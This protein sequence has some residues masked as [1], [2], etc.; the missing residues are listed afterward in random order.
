MTLPT[1]QPDTPEP[2]QET[3][4][5]PVANAWARLRRLA[6]RPEV[7]IAL[8]AFLW[9]VGGKLVAVRQLRSSSLLSAGIAV[10]C[11]DVVFF[12]GGLLLLALMY[13][14][15]PHRFV[16]R[17]AL[18]AAMAMFGW[19]VLNTG[20]LVSTGVQLQP[21]IIPALRYDPREFVAIVGAF[22]LRHLDLVIPAALAGLG[23]AAWF[24]WRLVKPLPVVKTRR[25]HIRSAC[26]GL[27]V[28]V[29]A[30]LVQVLH[31]PPASLGFQSEVLG[32]S[33]HWYALV[34]VLDFSRAPA[35]DVVAHRDLPRAGE[36]TIGYPD[37]P[38]EELP[39]IVLL[40]LESV[41]HDSTSLEH[42]DRGTTPNLVKLASE[43][44]EF[45]STRVP[46]S[47]TGKA[48]WATLIGTTPEIHHDYSEAILVDEPYESLATILKRVG[49]R[50]AFFEMSKGTF[51]C[52]PAVFANAGFDWGWWFENLGD[53][54]ASLGYLAGDDFR[55]LGPAFSWADDG[56]GPFLL[57]MITTVAHDPYELP[58]RYGP[59]TGERFQD[60]LRTIRFTDDFVGEVR[61]K[62]ETRGLLDKTII[63]VLGDHGE[64]FRPE[65]RRGRWVPYEE[66]I[67]VPWI[68]RWPGH[69][70][71]GRRVE[72]PCSQMDVTP[73]LLSLLGFDI[74]KAGFD[75]RNAL[76]PIAPNRR[77]YFSSWFAQSPLGFVE[78]D[79]KLIYWPYVDKVFECDL[80]SD[81]GEKT[82]Q[83]VEG[84]EKDSIIADIS[85]WQEE[86]RL[87]FDAR[88]FR[89]RVL[90]THWHA[91]TSGRS[92]WAYYEP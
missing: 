55:M 37:T 85:Q 16:A 81:P 27:A 7:I 13:S 6:P 79:R 23:L 42:T 57:M 53:P 4:S 15:A 51:E 9:T 30:L 25:P 56:S 35:T 84:A 14:L 46:V 32:F 71:A 72:W 50:S 52:A 83:P 49:Y 80:A 1:S 60:Y 76:A 19:A 61:G 67:R 47:Q 5:T 90:F 11:P 64:S 45:I 43:G 17:L 69:V 65:S 73:T 75:G 28:I 18:L 89:E 48:Y 88:R 34:S 87:F 86:S 22:M 59:A 38:A 78:G 91:F 8:V 31:R 33:S 41:S 82:L 44:T 63:C 77:L 66:V 92:A 20:W 68:I 2:P 12:A 3:G 40:L 24:L 29:L 36:R 10:A 62:L 21:S 54:G 58:A 74:S 39:N 70:T 26:L